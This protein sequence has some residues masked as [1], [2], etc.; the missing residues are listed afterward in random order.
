MFL[1]Q[2]NNLKLFMVLLGCKPPGR[3]TEQHD[4]FFGI[5]RSLSEV[6]KDMIDFWKEADG[7]IHIDGWRE[8]QWVDEYKVEVVAKE[9][10]A[11]PQQERLFFINL[12]GYK[13]NEFEEFHYKLITVAADKGIA[14]QRAKQTAFYKHT[15][16]EG[17]VSHIDD[18]YGVD[19]DDIYEI[20]DILP[21]HLKN[22]YSLRISQA[23][24]GQEDV[25]H[26][27]YLK[28]DKI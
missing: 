11:S 21:S 8:V 15:G 17:A 12:G 20:E 28:I 4:L 1:P 25:L 26:L 14:V 24:G 18:K 23:A 19:V 6:K 27:G 22:Q 7:K 16:F 10:S 2:M 9:N 5:G 13:Q 3:N